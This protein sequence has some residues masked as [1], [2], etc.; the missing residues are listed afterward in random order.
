[1]LLTGTE[2]SILMKENATFSGPSFTGSRGLL[3]IEFVFGANSSNVGTE[4]ALKNNSK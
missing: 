1:M 4:L 3:K 2:I